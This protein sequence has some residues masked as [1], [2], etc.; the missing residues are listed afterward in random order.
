[1]AQTGDRL[2]GPPTAADTTR[3]LCE[4]RMLRSGFEEIEKWRFLIDLDRLYMVKQERWHRLH[5]VPA[6]LLYSLVATQRDFRRFK[7]LWRE[8]AFLKFTVV[9]S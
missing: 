3:E 6:F 9:S 7:T 4:S 5:S 8:F 1:V 2:N